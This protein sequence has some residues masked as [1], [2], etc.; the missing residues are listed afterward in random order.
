M[1]EFRRELLT[2]INSSYN[3]IKFSIK[4]IKKIRHV[5]KLSIVLNIIHITVGS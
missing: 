3:S 4:K 1:E 5:P 2:G